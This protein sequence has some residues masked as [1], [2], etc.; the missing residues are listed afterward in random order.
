MY[1]IADDAVTLSLCNLLMLFL[2]LPVCGKA[3]SAVHLF[4]LCACVFCRWW[5]TPSLSHIVSVN[6]RPHKGEGISA[7]LV[8]KTL[9][10]RHSVGESATSLLVWHLC[11]LITGVKA[12]LSD[13]LSLLVTHLSCCGPGA[14]SQVLTDG[15]NAG[16]LS[17]GLSCTAHRCN[18]CHETEE[19]H[20]REKSCFCLDDLHMGL[21]HFSWLLL[22]FSQGAQRG[23]SVGAGRAAVDSAALWVFITRRV[24]LSGQGSQ[25]GQGSAEDTA[26]FPQE[27]CPILFPHPSLPDRREPR[28][29]ALW[30]CRGQRPWR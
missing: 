12:L 21:R 30:L 11:G 2:L 7:Q 9:F 24:S 23:C 6:S 5:V 13:H 10:L 27:T 16:G 8:N 17:H 25:H 26:L 22:H 18:S 29:L 15:G 14:G 1:F 28:L 20:M 3:Y 4:F 19:A